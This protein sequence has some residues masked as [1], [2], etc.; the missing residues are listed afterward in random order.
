M[1]SQAGARERGIRAYWIMIMIAKAIPF[2]FG[3]RPVVTAI[4]VSFRFICSFLEFLAN[5]KEDYRYNGK[6]VLK[7][8]SDRCSAAKTIIY[9]RY[10]GGKRRYVKANRGNYLFPRKQNGL[11]RKQMA[12]MAGDG[13]P[14]GILKEIERGRQMPWLNSASERSLNNLHLPQSQTWMK[15]VSLFW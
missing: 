14:A 4:T 5:F 9:Y 10:S 2:P 8:T 6:Y 1:C 11:S 7:F 3:F 15:R 12:D 13:I